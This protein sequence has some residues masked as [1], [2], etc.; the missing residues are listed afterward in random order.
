[1]EVVEHPNLNSFT[2]GDYTI[3]LNRESRRISCLI[4]DTG[5]MNQI[6]AKQARNK[7]D[8]MD[9]F[10]ISLHFDEE[11]AT[12]INDYGEQFDQQ[13]KHLITEFTDVTKEPQRLPPH[14]GHLDH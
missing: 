10:L 14:R 6:I 4:V 11:L 1:M 12:V 5:K 13:L 7:K 9:V 3:Q 2:M 8:P